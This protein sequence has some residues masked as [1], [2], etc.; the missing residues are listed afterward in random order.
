MT[1]LANGLPAAAKLRLDFAYD[2]QGRRIQKIVYTNSGSAYYP[3]ST[4]R[5]VYD[6]WNLIGEFVGPGGTP[7]LARSY[8]WGLDLSG[9]MQGAGGVGG[10]LAVTDSTPGTNFVALRRQRQR[11][12]LGQ[13]RRW[14]NSRPNTNTAPSG[15]SSATHR[16]HGQCQSLPVLDQVSR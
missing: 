9:S 11:R 10:L 8:L 6:G 14:H 16:P 13:R 15:N 1:A 7:T 12:S 3:H 4:N 2:Y 5:F